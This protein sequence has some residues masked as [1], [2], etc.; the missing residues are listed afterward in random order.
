MWMYYT[1]EATQWLQGIETKTIKLKTYL[2]ISTQL[3]VQCF[4]S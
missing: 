3:S 1:H 2:A 4:T